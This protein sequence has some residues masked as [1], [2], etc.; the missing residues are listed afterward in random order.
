MMRIK[1]NIKTLDTGKRLFSLFFF[2]YKGI[3]NKQSTNPE[4]IKKNVPF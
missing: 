1:K 2:K 4:K 3:Q